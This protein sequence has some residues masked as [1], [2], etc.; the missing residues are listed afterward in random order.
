M[1]FFFKLIP[2]FV[3]AHT[4][5]DLV[6]PSKQPDFIALWIS[7]RLS[8]KNCNSQNP[9][10]G[11]HILLISLHQKRGKRIS[12]KNPD[13]TCQTQANLNLI[14]PATFAAINPSQRSVYTTTLSLWWQ[15]HIAGS[16]LHNLN[17]IFVLYHPFRGEHDCF[18][19][20]PGL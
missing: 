6:L 10:K 17:S 15:A 4:G 18:C 5:F 11:G 2:H 8:C 19:N 16:L 13:T 14:R 1:P 3:F 7:G 20:Y 12:H 9:V